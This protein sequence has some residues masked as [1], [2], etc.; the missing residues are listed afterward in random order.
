M[1]ERAAG[2]IDIG[3][4]DVEAD[5]VNARRQMAQN[6][7]GTAANID[8]AHAWTKRQIIG[9][10]LEAGTKEATGVLI[11]LIKRGMLQDRLHRDISSKTWLRFSGPEWASNV[12]NC[13]FSMSP[14]VSVGSCGYEPGNRARRWICEI[15]NSGRCFD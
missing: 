3:L 2:V 9:D 15:K 12:L 7:T 13:T 4:I 6:M 10:C 5:V 14:A 1:A 11:G 8:H